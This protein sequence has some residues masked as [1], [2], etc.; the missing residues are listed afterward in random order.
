MQEFHWR[1]V[2]EKAELSER[3][4]KLAAFVFSEIFSTLPEDE[5]AR[6]RRQLSVMCEYREILR[7]RIAAFAA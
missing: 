4:D 5:Q 7:Q 1:V 2:T 3:T 6:L